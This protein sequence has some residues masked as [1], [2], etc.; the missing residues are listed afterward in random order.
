MDLQQQAQEF[1]Y[2]YGVDNDASKRDFQMSLI[3]EEYKEL[4]EAHTKYYD[5]DGAPA[6]NLK[7]LADLVYVCYQYAEN[8]DWDLN[9]ALFRVHRSNMS[10]L[11][12]DGK[13]V[14][15]A[16]GK[17]M[18]GP[19]YRPPYLDDLTNTEISLENYDH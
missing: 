9:E 11:G 4:I 5:Y 10:K 8:L 17:V 7:E 18:K 19:N 16:S 1:R 12:T 2:A 3:M 6:D 13:P 15:N 14:K